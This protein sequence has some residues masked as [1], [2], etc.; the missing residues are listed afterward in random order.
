[1][2]KTRLVTEAAALSH[3]E[4]TAGL[5]FI[6][7]SAV[8]DAAL[9]LPSIAGSIGLQPGTGKLPALLADRL[10]GGRP[11]RCSTPSSTCCRPD[12]SSPAWPQA[13]RA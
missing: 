8:G 5:W 2:G 10:S 4:F 11:L 3:D 1:V 7:M 9:V 13:A 12:R 6:D